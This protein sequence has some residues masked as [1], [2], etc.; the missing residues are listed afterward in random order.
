M[1]ADGDSAEARGLEQKAILRELQ[2]ARMKRDKELGRG[3]DDALPS[4][5]AMLTF[6]TVKIQKEM[7]A[8]L[9]EE[10]NLLQARQNDA[11]SDW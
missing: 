2:A 8:R 9:A 11:I 4:V 1:I 7:E 5:T 6:T 3:S 10:Q